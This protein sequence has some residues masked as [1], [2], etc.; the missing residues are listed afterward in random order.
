[1][2]KI[3]SH[4]TISTS[5]RSDYTST[6]TRKNSNPD[7]VEETFHV[8]YCSGCGEYVLITDKKIKVLPKRRTDGAAILSADR[9]YKTNLKDGPNI[10]IKR[11]NGYEPHQTLSCPRCSLPIAYTCSP[12]P[13]PQAPTTSSEKPIVYIVDNAVTGGEAQD[14]VTGG[15]EELQRDV[16]VHGKV[17]NKSVAPVQTTAEQII[18][19]GMRAAG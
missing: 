11:P 13:N 15:M 4:S 6:N 9:T 18:R 8:Y 12:L 1:M 7:Q 17:M 3:I 10:I 5:E 2:P 14:S 19:T 16:L